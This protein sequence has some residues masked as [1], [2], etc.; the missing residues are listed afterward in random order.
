MFLQPIV[1][2]GPMNLIL[3]AKNRQIIKGQVKAD[4]NILRTIGGIQ[5]KV[6]CWINN[7]TNVGSCVYPDFCAYIK[8]IFNL[9]ENNCPQHLI[10]NDIPCTCPFNLPIRDV[11]IN[12][13][14]ESSELTSFWVNNP[15][16]IYDGILSTGDFDVTIKLT[17]GT[18]NILCLNTKFTLKK[19]FTG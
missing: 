14:F 15:W 9:N 19:T 16:N 1:L 18:T 17:I 5:L 10:N 3:D 4:V 6:S 11:N 12:Q 2:P 13:S 7:G 8:T